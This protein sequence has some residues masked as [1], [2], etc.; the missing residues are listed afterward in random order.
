MPINAD[1]CWSL[2]SMPINT[3]QTRSMPDQFCLIWHWLELRGI[4]RNWSALFS[5]DW[6]WSTLGSK[7]EFWSALLGIGHWSRESYKKRGIC[8][9]IF[10]CWCQS[11]LIIAISHYGLFTSTLNDECNFFSVWNDS[12][13]T[14]DRPQWITVNN[15]GIKLVIEISRKKFVPE[16]YWFL[17]SLIK[18][19]NGSW[20]LGLSA[21]NQ[22]HVCIRD[23]P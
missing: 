5:I 17:R 16:I 19:K 4:G 21:H 1:K 22:I 18:D 12:K 2:R 15:Q 8:D 13:R 11:R 6:N 14:T 20:N 3:D 9:S 10:I 7:P 23:R